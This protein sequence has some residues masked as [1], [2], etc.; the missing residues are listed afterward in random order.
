MDKQNC[1]YYKAY[2]H[3][4]KSKPMFTNVCLWFM[5]ENID[6]NNDCEGCPYD[7]RRTE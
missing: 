3:G 2:Y 4:F 1:K 5:V 7:K 6:P